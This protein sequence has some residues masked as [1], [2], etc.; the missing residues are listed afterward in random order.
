MPPRR[1]GIQYSPRGAIT[2]SSA[3]ADDD[4]IEPA[5]VPAHTFLVRS[6]ATWIGGTHGLSA[7]A[8]PLRATWT[9]SR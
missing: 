8:T 7:H 9:S 2:G 4:N 1:R 6:E 3:F 5:F